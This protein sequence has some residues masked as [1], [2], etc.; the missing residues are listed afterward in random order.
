ME[1]EIKADADG[2]NIEITEIQGKEKQLLE[3]FQECQEGRCSCPTNEYSKL[4]SLEI[5]QTDG[6]IDFEDRTMNNG[7]VYTIRVAKMVLTVKRK[8]LQC[9]PC[10]TVWNRDFNSSRNILHI[11][12]CELKSEERPHY[13][14]RSR[15]S[16]QSTNLTTTCG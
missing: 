3:A 11:L 14:S 12:D 16:R 9:G 8:V 2:L 10:G 5:K 1:K 4:E 6:R 15:G 13:L 7:V